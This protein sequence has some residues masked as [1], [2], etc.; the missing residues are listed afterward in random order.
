VASLLIVGS[1]AKGRLD[2]D[3]NYD[4]MAIN[5]EIRYWTHAKH[6]TSVH[7]LFH[8]KG[9]AIGHTFLNDNYAD[10]KWKYPY[11]GGTSGLFAVFGAQRLGYRKIAL[12]GVPLTEEWSDKAIINTWKRYIEENDCGNVRSYSGKTLELLGDAK[13]WF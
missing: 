13:G 10:C 9:N 3:T 8:L 11:K 2:T 1:G 5:K 7:H 12:Y 6:F 4:V